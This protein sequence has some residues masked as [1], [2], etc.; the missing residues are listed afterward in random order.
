MIGIVVVAVIV[1]I[2]MFSS[3]DEPALAPRN[4]PAPVAEVQQRVA[5]AVG[6]NS[7][8]AGASQSTTTANQLIFLAQATGYN[9]IPASQQGKRF[10]SYLNRLSNS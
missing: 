7:V 4:I 8:F 10:S 3:R 6:A 1:G 5:E 2:F 9:G